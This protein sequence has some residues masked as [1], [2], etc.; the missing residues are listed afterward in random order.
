MGTKAGISPVVID[1]ELSEHQRELREKARLFAETEIV[2]RARELDARGEFPLDIIKKA[3]ESGF[4][5]DNVP[6]AYGGA[7]ASCLD[8]ALVTEELGAGCMGCATTIM[9]NGLAL[10]PIVLFGSEAQ[11]QKYLTPF[12]REFRLGAFCLTEREA[13]SD[14]GSLQTTA[15]RDGGDYVLNGKKC[16]I[17]NG[18]YAELF[19]VFA[20]SDPRKGIRGLS[21]FIVE[22][23]HGVQVGK[24]EDKMGQRAAN[25]TELLFENVRVPASNLLEREGAGFRIAMG[26]LDKTRTA[27]A[28]GAVGIARRALQEAAAYA[29]QRKQF[30]QA[31][32]ANQAIQFKIAGMALKVDAARLL[33]WHAAWMADKGLRHAKQSAMAKCFAGDTAMEVTTEAV[34]IF[35]GNG[36]SKD[37]PVEKLMRDAKL[38]QIYE[39]TQEIQRLIIAK[40]VLLKGQIS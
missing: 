24:T 31:I 5:N 32:A 19:V 20:S 28:A 26:T 9:A 12:T 10:T 8:A 6:K 38:L 7:G 39:G 30:G 35:G 13:G 21:A 15:T 40:E 1:F 11:K 25:Q 14:V 3:F 36:Y 22:K 34:Q 2:P 18:G 29:K 17:T 37:Y 16:F 4:L 33:T 23:A 27:A